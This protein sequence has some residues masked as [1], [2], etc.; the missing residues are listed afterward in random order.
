[1]HRKFS[2]NQ[3]INSIM[4]LTKSNVVK[5]AAGVVIGGLITY[6]IVKSVKGGGTNRPKNPRTRQVMDRYGNTITIPEREV[7]GG[8]TFSNTIS[9]MQTAIVSVLGLVQS[10]GAVINGIN[11]VFT[12]DNS[13]NNQ[14]Y[15]QYTPQDDFYTYRPAGGYYQSSTP[16][17][18]NS[19]GTRSARDRGIH[20]SLY[21]LNPVTPEDRRLD[22]MKEHYER[23][24]KE[25]KEDFNIQWNRMRDDL[26]GCFEKQ[27]DQLKG[28]LNTHGIELPD[29]YLSLEENSERKKQLEKHEEE[30]IHQVLES[31][32][33]SEAI[34]KQINDRDRAL[35]L[36]EARAQVEHME[37][38]G[39]L[40]NEAKS[41]MPI[42][43]STPS[44]IY[45]PEE[46]TPENTYQLP[47]Y[48]HITI[49]QTQL[50][51][52]PSILQD[53]FLQD[54]YANGSLVLPT[55]EDRE[56]ELREINRSCGLETD[57]EDEEPKTLA[58]RGVTTANLMDS[59]TEYLESEEGYSEK[60]V[61]PDPPTETLAPGMFIPIM[62]PAARNLELAFKQDPGHKMWD[63]AE[64]RNELRI[65][66]YLAEV[67]DNPETVKKYELA[68]P[69]SYVPRNYEI[70]KNRPEVI[71]KEIKLIQHSY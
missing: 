15:G 63:S 42:N 6:G 40:Q 12:D 55:K 44:K 54:E 60:L 43:I 4:N 50:N 22:E 67:R 46:S 21:P 61:V 37:E 16:P 53:P 52:C 28:Q 64:K 26:V 68:V 3:K 70:L 17:W 31:V 30:T 48:P 69:N 11:S 2:N 51:H 58:E 18:S 13:L 9:D 1:M 27:I 20:N 65:L 19:L 34:K 23:E 56:Q 41:K 66:R 5:I 39:R 45:R 32:K 59:F 35:E 24:M 14:Y 62:T 38:L 7:T 49:T 10:V 8:E 25:M 71:N 57:D 33:C 36:E 29:S 47:R